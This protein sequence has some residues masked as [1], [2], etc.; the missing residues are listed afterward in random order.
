[1]SLPIL[2]FWVVFIICAVF[3]LPFS[4]PL[5]EYRGWPVLVMLAILGWMCL[6]H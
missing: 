6:G 4:A 2:V 5:A 1:M 3:Q